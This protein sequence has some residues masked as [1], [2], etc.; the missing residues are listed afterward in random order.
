[1]K[2]KYLFIFSL[3]IAVVL[4]NYGCTSEPVTVATSAD[5]VEINFSNQGEGQ[6]AIVLVHGWTNNNTI[7][8]LQIPVLSEK[9]Q[10]PV[11]LLTDQFLNDSLFVSE[12][13]FKAPKSISRFITEDKDL[14]N[15]SQYN[16]YKL[17]KSGV[18]PRALPYNGDALVVVT[19]NEHG[20]DGHISEE[21]KDRMNMAS[22]RQAKV[23]NMLKEM[24]LEH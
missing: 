5:G 10:V 24:T 8:D 1:M 7:W 9:Y 4:F 15:P 6:P 18:S 17:T 22:K 12:K 20:E 21:I 14:K 2:H 3:F 16:R 11:I 23:K 19:G 13:P